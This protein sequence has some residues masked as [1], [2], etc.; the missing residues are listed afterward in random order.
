MCVCLYAFR[1]VVSF[2]TF[3]LFVSGGLK[4]CCSLFKM[5]CVCAMVLII[6]FS[7]DYSAW[8]MQPYL[9]LFFAIKT[10]THIQH[11]HGSFVLAGG[12]MVGLSDDA[13]SVRVRE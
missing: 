2:S 10:Q 1:V 12:R 4:N 8:L 5:A 9:G 6:Q 3:I 11:T 7:L 13:H